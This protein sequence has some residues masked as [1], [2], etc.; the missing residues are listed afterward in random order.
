VSC[1]YCDADTEIRAYLNGMVCPAHTPA[2]QA[3]RPE[4]VPDPE[5]TLDALRP[6]PYVFNLN[7]TALIDQRAVASG[8][9]RSTPEQYRAA[10]AAEAERKANR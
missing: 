2:R 4:H 5:L 7:D 6:A 10:Q 1:R 8:R 3:G 9:R